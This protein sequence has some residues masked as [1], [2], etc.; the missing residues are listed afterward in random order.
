MLGELNAGN[1]LAR[2]SLEDMRSTAEQYHGHRVTI[3][4]A[5]QAAASTEG[6]LSRRFKPGNRHQMNKVECEKE[7]AVQIC[8][9]RERK[10][11]QLTER[12]WG[13]L[14]RP[15]RTSKHS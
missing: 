14:G 4:A 12:R 9:R 11:E 10:V 8:G 5:N 2:R 1:Y 15:R 13:L 3:Q 7:Q 6:P